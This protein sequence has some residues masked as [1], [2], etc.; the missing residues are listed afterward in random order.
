MS[1]LNSC[2][3]ARGSSRGSIWWVNNDVKDII[4]NWC[5]TELAK[6]A[7]H[8]PSVMEYQYRLREVDRMWE[9]I[10]FVAEVTSPPWAVNIIK[11]VNTIKEW[12]KKL[13]ESLINELTLENIRKISSKL[14]FEAQVLVDILIRNLYER[15]ADV[16]FLATDDDIRNYLISQDKTSEDKDRIKSRLDEYRK[17]YTV[18]DE[19]IIFDTNWNVVVNLND[20]NDVISSSEPLIKAIFETSEDYIE[21]F[22]KLDF[23]K[24]KDTTPLVYSK[25]I[26][27]PNTWENIWVLC[28]VFRFDDEME[29]IYQKLTKDNDLSIKLLLDKDGQ[30]ISSSDQN[31]V[32]LNIK[33]ERIDKDKDYWIIRFAGKY[34]VASTK[35]TNWYQWYFWLWWQWQTMI[36]L[37]V[38][39]ENN[40][41]D[42]LSKIDSKIL[43][44]VLT[45]STS[46]C[47]A[48]WKI[49]YWAS[50]I[51][52]DLKRIVWNWQI[53][54]SSI[55][56]KLE[57]LLSTDG[58]PEEVKN[59]ILDVLQKLKEVT[60]SVEVIEKE[61]FA[62]FKL[63]LEKISSTWE[64]TRRTFEDSIRN[65]FETIL[66]STLSEVENAANLA[67]DIMD[68][69]LY[70]RANDCRWWAL[71]SKIREILS[72]WEINEEDY[73]VI[74]TILE[75][76][77]ELYKVYT[78][79][80]A[81]DRNG[82]ILTSSVLDKND[83][84]D[85]VWFN[86]WLESW[87]LDNVLRLETTQDYCVTPFK[88]SKLYNDRQTY[89]YHAWIRY[90]ND[91]SK[92]VGWIWIVFDSWPELQAMLNAALPKKEW[93]FWLF[94]DTDWNVI[95]STTN[96]YMIW[97]KLWL[98]R[99]YFWL[100]NWESLSDIVVLNGQYYMMW[101]ASSAWYRE[102]KNTGDYENNIL[103]FIFS[104]IWKEVQASDE[105]KSK[106]QVIHPKHTS[107]DNLEIATFYLN[108]VLYWIESCNIIEAIK[109]NIT[110]APL[111]NNVVWMVRYDYK[112]S[113]KLITVV[114][115]NE[116][117][118]GKQ[119]ENGEDDDFKN[120]QIVILKIWE[121]LVWILV[122]DL[123]WVHVYDKHNMQ[124]VKNEPILSW[125][126]GYVKYFAKT[127]SDSLIPT[128]A[129]L[130]PVVIY[131]ELKKRK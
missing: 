99:K 104:P 105:T 90:K 2:N 78:R 6:L 57:E 40:Q 63:I 77:N 38:A 56:E 30:V 21:T 115:M 95:S 31:I 68:R 84:A 121:E 62:K 76:I 23:I 11:T 19:I 126:T 39:F 120:K 124:D 55:K 53:M 127:D 28:L 54:S 46:F 73:L 9:Y 108:W 91:E 96:N 80:Y 60:A 92:I 10:A 42:V 111:P 3:T 20:S 58:L 100:R 117:L 36:P 13:E 130:D 4:S 59:L 32:P 7:K 43:D 114:D 71:T 74:N 12:F 67:I 88:N 123:E 98:D 52:D 112:W 25:K 47:P 101:V 83:K 81:Y 64:A 33:V 125:K 79:I 86:V 69:N 85:I 87:I 14:S 16:W 27:D 50:L 122:D 75:Y 65:L 66:L 89:S 1:N 103:S 48:L 41:D 35:D 128:F 17:K 34:Y 94:T 129:V 72:K 22:Q 116:V 70:E 107:N 131:N 113:D 118:N 106:Q 15:T 119:A 102:Y 29:R 44:W 24:H 97:A 93:S 51:N 82:Y 18:Y 26:I 110:K 8:I 37:D 61:T 49:V 45:H 109:P 5:R